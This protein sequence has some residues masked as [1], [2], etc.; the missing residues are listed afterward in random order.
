VSE[1]FLSSG[2]A[3]VS[4]LLTRSAVVAEHLKDQP[5][6][7]VRFSLLALAGLSV[8]CASRAETFTE[9]FST[10]PLQNG[11]KVFANTNLFQW[12]STNQNL[13]VTWDSSQCN[14]YFYHPLGTIL[15]TNDAFSVEFDLQ[16]TGAVTE[17]Y[18]SELGI[19]FLHLADA[20][21]A[22][23]LR[24]SGSSPN[25]AEFDYFPPSL[26]A[27][28]IDATLIDASNGFYFAFDTEPLNPGTA[29][30]V[31]LAH[32][33]GDL[34]VSAQ[35]SANGQI[36]TSLPQFYGASLVD[37]RL[38]IL[39]ISSYQGDGWGDTIYAQGVLD[40]FVV[41]LPPPPIQNLAGAFSNGVWQAQFCSQS[42]WLYALERTSD[43]HSWT[44]IC[45]ATPGN[46]TNVFLQDTN[47]PAEKAFYRLSASRP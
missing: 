6:L 25:V 44:N 36:F 21:N 20:T 18:G 2:S 38:D 30:H 24:T 32:A 29:Y 10:D 5:M 40:N 17:N 9:D 47:P 16:L 23:F 4:Q 12:D 13:A 46:A 11:W 15:T 1:G 8:M 14:S 42:N 19:G 45:P 28:S 22:D 31:R 39:A 27:P 7:K 35:V 43:F 3:L 34:T 41:T 33:A 37:F 26:I